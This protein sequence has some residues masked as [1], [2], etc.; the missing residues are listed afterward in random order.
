MYFIEY[1]VKR[2][3]KIVEKNCCRKENR[4]KKPRTEK[5]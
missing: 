3:I 4:E 2:T 5:L 1:Y